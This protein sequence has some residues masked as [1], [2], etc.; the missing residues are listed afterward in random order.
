MQQYRI[1]LT[2]EN[3]THKPKKVYKWHSCKSLKEA[4]DFA[5]EACR[6]YNKTHKHV[7]VV[8]GVGRN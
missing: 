8:T 2:I 7:A 4:W 6:E 5:R 3:H 1:I